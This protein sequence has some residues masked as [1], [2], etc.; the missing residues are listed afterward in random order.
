M[1]VCVCVYVCVCLKHKD[2]IRQKAEHCVALPCP[3][4]SFSAFPWASMCFGAPQCPSVL[5]SVAHLPSASFIVVQ[6]GAVLPFALAHF[7]VL[8]CPS[9]LF[10]VL[11]FSA[12]QCLAVGR[13]VS[14]PRPPLQ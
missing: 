10:G 6:C 5:L 7:S 14:Y 3:S 2:Q 13:I 4:L 1:F 8:Q 12:L 11:F 9:V